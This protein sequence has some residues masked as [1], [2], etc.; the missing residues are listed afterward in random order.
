MPFIVATGFTAGIGREALNHLARD[1]SARLLLGVRDTAR[2]EAAL[3][4]L[5]AAARARIALAPLDMASLVSVRGFAEAVRARGAPDILLLNAG[6]QTTHPRVTQDGFEETFGVNHLA[7]YLLARLLASAM[8]AGGRI[9]FTSSGTHDPAERTGMPAPRHA[10]ARRLAFPAKD[11]QRDSDLGVACRRAYA[12]SKLC[13]VMTARTLAERLAPSRADVMVA[14]F[15]PGFTPGT[16]LARAYPAPL[17]LIWHTILPLGALVQPRM[18]TPARSGRLLAQLAISPAYEGARG[19]YFAVRGPNLIEKAPS[20]L[21]QDPQ[22]C[23]K[24]WRDSAALVGLD[25]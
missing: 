15:D 22:A 7:H 11:P 5:N 23:A 14:A 24:L 19:A 17:R 13:N 10:D 6:G 8:A 2:A 9:V 21:A 18:S 25:D 3:R 16:G 20:E 4:G 12:T 1:G